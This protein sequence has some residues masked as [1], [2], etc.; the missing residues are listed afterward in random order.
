[1][2]GPGKVRAG[3]EGVVTLGVYANLNSP[4][5]LLGRAGMVVESVSDIRS[6]QWGKLVINAAINPLAAILNVPNGALLDREPARSLLKTAAREAASVAVALGV[7][8]PYPDPVVATEA[9]ASRTAANIASMLQDVRRGAPTEIDVINGAIVKA[10]E[11]KGVPT[12]VNR[13]LTL[14]VRALRSSGMD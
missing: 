6:V 3:G 14:L 5:D 9:I 10:G 11:K 4:A 8:L 12:P 2:L 1:M 13:T 7:H